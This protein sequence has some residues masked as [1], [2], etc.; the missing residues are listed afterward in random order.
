[1]QNTKQIQ[2]NKKLLLQYLQN[3]EVPQS[4]KICFSDFSQI[5]CIQVTVERRG[6]KTVNNDL[7]MEP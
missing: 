1:M 2:E 6:G 3:S 4:R 5:V 7:S